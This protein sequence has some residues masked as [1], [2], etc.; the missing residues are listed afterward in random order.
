MLRYVH[1]SRKI[2][3]DRN[4]WPLTNIWHHFLFLGHSVC[5]CV[6]FFFL[7]V[8]ISL[9]SLSK[10][11]LFPCLFAFICCKS[12]SKRSLIFA[13]YWQKWKS[14]RLVSVTLNILTHINTACVW[15][16]A[17]ADISHS[18]RAQFDFISLNICANVGFYSLWLPTSLDFT[19]M[20]CR[21]CDLFSN[22]GA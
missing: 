21:L 18:S 15:S 12:Q 17:S 8:F 10:R 20:F 2:L 6:D 5:F 19:A 22:T 13:S 16:E 11:F 1:S 14:W 7:K 9:F 4:K 3:K